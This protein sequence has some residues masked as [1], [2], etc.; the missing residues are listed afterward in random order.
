M[1]WLISWTLP[2]PRL[3]QEANLCQQNIHPCL[4]PAQGSH[5]LTSAPSPQSQLDLGGSDCVFV[6]EGQVVQG[7]FREVRVWR[8]GGERTR[9]WH[10]GR[11][12]QKPFMGLLL[13]P[14]VMAKSP[15][16]RRP[17]SPHSPL[18]CHIGLSIDVAPS[19]FM[20]LAHAVPSV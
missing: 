11:L 20:A 14:T 19:C 12:G 17:P 2:P 8:N 6:L 10:I 1:T 9:Q 5:F 16:V 13:A 7:K 3:N 15:P 4:S 18:F